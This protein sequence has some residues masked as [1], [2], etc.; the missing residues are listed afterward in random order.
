MSNPAE[1]QRCECGHARDEHEND[2]QDPGASECKVTGCDCGMF[3]VEWDDE[4]DGDED[5]E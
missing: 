3:E 4:W 2:P 1:N 5:R